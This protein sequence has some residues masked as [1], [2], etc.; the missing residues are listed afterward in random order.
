VDHDV[1]VDDQRVDVVTLGDV[2]LAV[3]RLRPAM[4]GRIEGA[5]SHPQDALDV[6]VAFELSD[7]R[8]ADLARRPGD[9]D[10]ES[11]AGQRSPQQRVRN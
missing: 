5:P 9:G 10:S 11:H 7:G 8:H 4:L 2:A 3:F 1:G 6:G